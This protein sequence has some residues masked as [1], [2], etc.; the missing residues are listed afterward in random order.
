[1]VFFLAHRIGGRLCGILAAVLVATDSFVVVA[2]RTARPEAET[3]LLCWLALLLCERAIARHSLKLGFAS[4]L[5]CGLGMF[6]HPLALAFFGA[7]VLFCWMEYGWTVWKE[8]LAWVMVAGA[9]VVMVPYFL[10]CFSDAAHIASFRYWYVDTPAAPFRERLIGEADRWSDFIGISSQR[11]PLL[12]HVPLRLHVAVILIV[13][14]AFFPRQNRRFGLA[15]LTLLAVNLGWLLFLVN[16]GPRYLVM[17]SPLFAI[18]L[19]YFAARST[20]RWYHKL[21][22]AAMLL[23]LLTQVG[24][25]VYWLYR[26]RGANYQTLSRQLQS[27]VPPGAS[28]YG[29]ET[30]WMALNDRVYYAYD[31][32]PLKLAVE[33][34][35]PEYMILYDR[36]MMHGSG[37]GDDTF[38]DLRTQA[39]AFVR[40][41]GVLAGRV[42]NEFYGD[43]EIYRISY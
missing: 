14:L 40:D 37:H 34:L 39:T 30:F 17:L 25:N 26:Y 36:V 32:T 3:V 9:F 2:S 38:G 19:A 31:R 10:W 21:A 1:V 6:C 13:A 28:V 23:V 7:M 42:S 4:G 11:V 16:K 27:I 15:G 5:A 8:P 43:L 29:I 35:H 24:G 20:G 18:V 33:K 22:V 12:N 41:H